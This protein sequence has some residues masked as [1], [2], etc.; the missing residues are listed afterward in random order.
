M[1]IRLRDFGG[2]IPKIDNTKLPESSAQFANNVD[3][4]SNTLRPINITGEFNQIGFNPLTT[5]DVYSITKPNAPTVK[6][7]SYK[8]DFT[9]WLKCFAF[10]YVTVNDLNN[11]FVKVD[12]RIIGDGSNTAP[13]AQSVKYTEQGAEITFNLDGVNTYT[14][15][16]GFKYQFAG[17]FY[18]FYMA[19][20]SNG[21]PEETLNIPS[22]MNSNYNKIIPVEITPLF[23]EEGNLYANL[24]FTDTNSGELDFDTVYTIEENDTGYNTLSVGQ[25]RFNVEMNYIQPTRQKYYYVQTMVEDRDGNY[26]EGPPSELSELVTIKPGQTVDILVPYAAGYTDSNLYRSTNDADFNKLAEGE[27]YEFLNGEYWFTDGDQDVTTETL[28]AYGNYPENVSI[29]QFL[30]GSFVHPAQFGV[31]F[32]GKNLYFSDYYRLH[33]WPEEYVISF[34]HDIL[35]IMLSG[36]TIIVFSTDGNVYGVTGGN[37]ATMSKYLIS[38]TAPLLNP[39]GLCQ[40]NNTI[41]YISND[42]LF[43]ITGGS[44]VNYTKD[45]YTRNEWQDLNPVTMTI[46]SLDNNIFME[47]DTVN[48][49]FDIEEGIKSISTFTAYS[50]VSLTWKT[51]KYHFDK[52]EVFDYVQIDSDGNVNLSVYVDGQFKSQYLINDFSPVVL[53]GIVHGYD[54]EFQVES[55][56]EIRSIDIFE[57]QVINVGESVS[58]NKVSNPVWESIYL[59]FPDRGSF[60][61][62]VMTVEYD[63]HV[64]NPILVEFI[65]ESLGLVHTQ[66]IVYGEL[67][68]LPESLPDGNL[69]RISVLNSDYPIESLVLFSRRRQII[70]D[71]VREFRTD[72]QVQPWA[73]KTYEAN[74]PINFSCAQ[75]RATRY[76]VVMNTYAEGILQSEI[77]VNSDKPFRLP[78]A[79]LQ[80]KFQFDLDEGYGVVMDFAVATSMSKLKG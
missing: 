75:I 60:A 31:A 12:Q 36:N 19:G 27:D 53:D 20:G 62:G 40:L 47:G 46:K 32:H 51:K 58:L 7:I 78:A 65:H 72:P 3:L 6:S 33:A 17:P 9:K 10:F 34:L 74:K 69:W 41:F 4:T 70:K 5:D 29:E 18:Y 79:R 11:N 37:P 43:G 76:P 61:G 67:F 48:L 26:K 28:P 44:S 54:W 64:N 56:S 55:D 24:E 2:L 63:Q 50:D 52:K 21:G 30:E 66:S 38:N 59:K 23:D 13:L 22:V 71:M 73:L 14:M 1:P 80:K 68:R 25:V 16:G 45:F 77:T 8:A 15:N 57:R 39:V 49:R 35:Y 42:G